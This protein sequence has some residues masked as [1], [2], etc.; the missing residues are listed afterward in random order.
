MMFAS[1]GAKFAAL[2]VLATMVSACQR[3]PD[4]PVEPEGWIAKAKFEELPALKVQAMKGSPS[5]ARML[6]R[7]Y[8]KL[9]DGEN[10]FEFWSRIAAENGSAAGQWNYAV[11][12]EKEK[13]SLSRI[14][15]R[16]WIERAAAQGDAMAR[17]RL[18]NEQE[19][20]P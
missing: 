18:K 12:L 8:M 17:N 20:R 2:V 13:D 3:S 9:P 4:D 16:F 11:S 5:A 1:F 14:R 10:T 15:A 19:H 7:H 6:A